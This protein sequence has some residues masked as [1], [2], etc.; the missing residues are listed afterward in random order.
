M[1]SIA[2]KLDQTI[3]KRELMSVFTDK[4]VMS[5]PIKK[6]IRVTQCKHF[7]KPDKNIPFGVTFPIG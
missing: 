2:I 7:S 5:K 6:K 4:F 1:I 3:F